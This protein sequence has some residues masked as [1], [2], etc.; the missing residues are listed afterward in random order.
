M[1]WFKR[2]LHLS[3][4]FAILAGFAIAIPVIS[5]ESAIL[6]YTYF[7]ILQITLVCIIAWIIREKRQ[8]MWCLLLVYWFFPAVFLLENRNTNDKQSIQT[9]PKQ[10]VLM[11][12]L[13]VIS[14]ILGIISATPLFLGF[15]RWTPLD[16][17]Y[18]DS[19]YTWTVYYKNYLFVFDPMAVI[20]FVSGLYVLVK[21]QS[22]KTLKRRTLFALV[23]FIAGLPII[24]IDLLWIAGLLGFRM[25]P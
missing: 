15:L 17:R 3:L 23:G 7:I 16:N 14:L 13:A 21:S 22:D 5:V 12:N 25:G 4:L 8:S 9:S 18:L 24:A 19:F 10:T 2:H 11:N 20:A 1:N 6:V